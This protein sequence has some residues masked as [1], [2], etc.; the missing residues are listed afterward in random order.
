MQD[1][2][3]ITKGT[4]IETPKSSTNVMVHSTK[5][6]KESDFIADPADPSLPALI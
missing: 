4:R 6:P 5:G 1:Q 3:N 2:M